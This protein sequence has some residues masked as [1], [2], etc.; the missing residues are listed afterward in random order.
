M[1]ELFDKPNLFD[2]SVRGLLLYKSLVT[3]DNL[4][5]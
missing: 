5:I 4:S 3:T 1:T 2:S